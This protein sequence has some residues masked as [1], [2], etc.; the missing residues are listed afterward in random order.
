MDRE[1][2]SLSLESLASLPEVHHPIASPDGRK[3]AFYYDED[4]RNEL[5]V[6]YRETGEYERLT[7][8]DV[9]RDANWLKRW[10]REGDRIYVHRDKEG[11]EQFDILSVSLDGSVETV[12]DVDGRAVLRDVATNS[13]SLLYAS[14]EVD[15]LNLYC[16]N[17]ETGNTQQL[18]QYEQPVYGGEFS[19]SG[20]QVAYLTNE[21]SNLDNQ[22]LY[23]MASDGSDPRRA[24]IGSRGSKVRFGGWF[25]D[26]ERLLVSDNTS[27]SRKVGIY[28]LSTE[29]AR[30]LSPEG[31]TNEES[32]VA[33][34]PEGRTVLT[35]RNRKA[36]RMPV[37]Y[38]IE[39]GDEEELNVPEGFL[40]LSAAVGESYADCS[41]LVFAHSSGAQRKQIYEYDLEGSERRV[42]LNASYGDID[43]TTFTEP[44]Y[45][46]YRSEDDLTIGG[47][48]YKS[49]EGDSR[50]PTEAPGIVMV[51]GG[52]HRQAYRRFNIYAQFLAS[53]G[54][55]VFQP[56]Y[57]G[58][59]GRGREFKNS[60]HNDWGGME[61]TDIATA[62]RWLKSH[63]WIDQNRIA[64]FGASYGGYSVYCQLTQYPRLWTT[65]VAWN[66]IT[67][68]HRLYDG[69]SPHIQ[70][71]LR[72]Q[73]G[74]PEEKTDL[75]R[76]RSP[77]EHVDKVE[78][79]MFILHGINDSRCPIEQA[80]L[81][82]DE[83]KRQGWESGHD[84]EYQ[85]LGSE[86][87]GSTDIQQKIRV[88]GLL[89][90]Y[91]NRRL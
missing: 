36:A 3:V 13:S 49:H 33:V 83:L 17:W 8:G 39:T 43:R 86:G 56:N 79:P 1:E 68:L 70:H 57:R 61:Q 6:L 85:E 32:A 74:N 19:P 44:E 22:D 52:P 11:D 50:T 90:D 14:D 62:G 82:R 45:V 77:I 65:G 54:Y 38:D 25:P 51:H 9:P 31:V 15:Q 63:E 26:D 89:A 42:L 78:R 23:V 71:H 12:I 5:Y 55:T 41:S 53:R 2:T 24:S 27:G 48:L 91:L 21:S 73:M 10:S 40:S 7:N 75:W 66:G 72:M 64:V 20:N 37:V 35:A 80:R 18:T 29:T 60:I 88:F 16:Y 87:H 58:S 28:D 67:D 4:G 76:E 30:W 81:F 46:T 69:V 84:F 47:L 59:T 34:G